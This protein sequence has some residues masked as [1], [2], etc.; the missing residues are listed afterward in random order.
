MSKT[1]PP[2]VTERQHRRQHRRPRTARSSPR[3]RR[4]GRLIGMAR[5]SC[6]SAAS[7][8]E[9]SRPARPP[10]IPPRRLHDVRERRGQR[11]RGE[12][13]AMEAIRH[14]RGRHDRAARRRARRPS[15]AASTLERSRRARLVGFTGE[16]RGGDHVGT[17]IA[18]RMKPRRE[19]QRAPSGAASSASSRTI[20][21]QVRHA[22]DGRPAI[23]ARYA[24]P[25]ASSS[26]AAGR[27][28]A[29]R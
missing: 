14:R 1:S 12:A 9:V 10:A 25:H 2:L 6:A 27:I 18:W 15:T 23:R 24:A 28:G 29:D 21:V 7:E 16:R 26:P 13:D 5:C 11:R 8:L 3:A 22:R 20:A 19:R 4:R 17:R